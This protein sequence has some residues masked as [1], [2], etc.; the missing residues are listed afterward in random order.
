VEDSTVDSDSQQVEFETLVISLK[1]DTD[2]GIEVDEGN[3]SDESEA[4]AL[5]SS[6][7]TD[8]IAVRR[9]R[10]EIRKPAKF[11]DMVAYALPMF[12]DDIPSTYKEVVRTRSP[13]SIAAAVIYII[14][15]LLDDKKPLK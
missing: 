10:R 2:N 3:S 14:T 9:A 15:Q 1:S 12:E 11:V 8:S 5:T 6:Q 13:I 7:L 4:P